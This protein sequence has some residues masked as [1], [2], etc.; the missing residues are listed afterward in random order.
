[1]SNSWHDD[2]ELGARFAKARSAEVLRA[3]S[4]ERVLRGRPPR[5]R[6]LWVPALALAA[7]V[8]AVGIGIWQA[9]SRAASPFEVTVGELSGPTDFLLR[10]SEPLAFEL[11]NIP[12]EADGLEPAPDGRI[13][14]TVGRNRL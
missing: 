9:E 11:P 10:T 1:M 8:L 12:L 13:G 7:M 2:V 6:S 5:R 4:F 3:P 14:D